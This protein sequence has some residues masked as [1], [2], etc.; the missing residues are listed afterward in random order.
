MN[1]R[2]AG[3]DGLRAI[4]IVWVMLFH[5]W[6]VGGLGERWSW[7]GSSG[8]MGVDLFFVLS[9][10]LIGSQVMAPLAR[11]ERL[12]FGDFYLRR[13]FRILPAFLVV[14]AVYVFVPG[15]REAP[16][17]EPAWKFLTFTANLSIDYAHNKAF[18][19]AWS[20][21]VEEHFYLLFPLSAVLFARGGTAR[22]FAWLVVAII[23]GGML[24]RGAIWQLSLAPVEHVDGVG[25]G[26]A[27]RYV[28][29]I[30]Y[31]TWNRLD[32]LVMGVAL[33]AI[34]TWRPQ[35]WARVEKHNGAIALVGFAVLAWAIVLCDER[36]DFIACVV[37]FPLLSF[38]M[39]LLVASAAFPGAW[40][41]RLT[42]PGAGWLAGASYSL[43]LVHKQ[44]FVAVNTRL[45]ESVDGELRFVVIAAAALLAGA[46][47]HYS[48]E[49]PGLR[50]RAS[51]RAIRAAT[52]MAAAA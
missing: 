14:L 38:G 41:S 23:V 52:P 44:V 29:D 17:M 26:F 22:R 46:V 3:L 5:S 28:E 16:D 19:H 6:L 47:L 11:G 40:L 34:R 31:P 10:Y 21:C 13:A 33:A 20:L 24:L 27:T 30:Y 36:T 42:P 32:G 35:W 1:T 2:V 18:S 49:R 15:F 12:A 9:G 4:A 51:V 48:V 43:Y 37:G 7:L 25:R 45:P 8:W 39:A 50:L